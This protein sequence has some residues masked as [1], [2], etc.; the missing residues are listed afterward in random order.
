MSP[1]DISRATVARLS[2]SRVPSCSLRSTAASRDADWGEPNGT[3]SRATYPRSIRPG[4][5]GST[6][7]PQR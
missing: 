2:G 1:T 4:V 6:V 7:L 5:I 3:N